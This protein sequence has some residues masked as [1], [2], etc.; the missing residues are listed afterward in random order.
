MNFELNQAIEILQRTPATLRSLLNGL[1]DFWIF[2]NEGPE[3][4]TPYD[5]IGHLIHAEDDD[6]IPRVKSI[7]EYG[8]SRAFEPFDRV[9]FF[10]KSKGKTLLELLDLFEAKREKN[11]Q[12]LQDLNL[13]SKHFD[14]KGRHPEFGLVTL[15]QLLATWVV[16]DMGHIAQIARTMAKQYRETVGPWKAYL[17][18]LNK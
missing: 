6:W 10:E 13:Q 15:R 3:T 16:H 9:A 11:L 14:L 1:S 7:L 5:V 8:D 12:V 2:N 4:W 17:S 18:I